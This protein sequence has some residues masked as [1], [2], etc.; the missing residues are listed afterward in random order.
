MKKKKLLRCFLGLIIVLMTVLNGC[1]S[2]VAENNA[3]AKSLATYEKL[4]FNNYDREVVIEA[5]PQKVLVFGPNNSELFVALGLSDKIIGNSYDNHSRGPLP[6]FVEDY[7]KIPELTYA[8]P[9]REAVISSGADFIYGN[10][11]PFGKEGLDLAELKE[12]GINVYMEKAATFEE[13]YQEISDLGKI[14]HVE[15]KAAA[16]IAD[17]KAR[18]AAVEKKLAG[19]E[20]LKVLVYDF[21]GEGVFTCSGTNFETL[22]I[23]KAGGKN[24][25]DDQTEKQ[26]FTASY[27]EIIKRNPDV[28]VI[29]DYDV[30]SLEEKIKSIKADP[31]LSKLDCVKNE[32]FIPI[33]LESVFP[34]DRMAYSVELLA[35]GFHPTLLK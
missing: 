1:S 13:I 8:D 22:L 15:D 2:K 24:I 28:I 5:M 33:A 19:Q 20:P 3:D 12:N 11:W 21:G 34:G 7:A 6:E 30:P 9:T 26:W 31:G 10:D 23:E 29:H 14:F 4:T 32:R 16:F 17:Q 35:K 18:I 27:E 25:F